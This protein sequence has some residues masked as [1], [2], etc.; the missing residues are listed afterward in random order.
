MCLT[1]Y[2]RTCYVRLVSQTHINRDGE[3]A[4]VCAFDSF[5]GDSYCRF[6][7]LRVQIKLG[8]TGQQEW[9]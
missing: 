1:S 3:V 9:A 7:D 6:V 4:F 2:V 8:R 5:F